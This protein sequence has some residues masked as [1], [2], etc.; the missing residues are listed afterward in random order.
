MPDP[1]RIL[2]THLAAVRARLASLNGPE[3]ERHAGDDEDLVVAGEHQEL[4][5]RDRDRLVAR[6]RALE[7][8][9]ERVEDGTYGVCDHCDHKL[10]E[11]RLEAIPEAALCI[12]CAERAEREARLI[13][14]EVGVRRERR[15]GRPVEEID[16]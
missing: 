6:V 9:I 5:T 13:E 8:A 3:P 4:A 12:G 2:E 11:A 10:P 16:G 15:A 1:R 14:P 7:A